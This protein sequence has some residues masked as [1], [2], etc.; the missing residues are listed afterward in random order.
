MIKQSHLA[1]KTRPQADPAH[2]GDERSRLQLLITELLGENQRLRFE[3]EGL[4]VLAQELD[5]QRQSVEAP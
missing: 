3:V 5:H 1:D 4:R 2:A